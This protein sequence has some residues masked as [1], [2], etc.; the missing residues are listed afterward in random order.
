M[1]TASYVTDELLRWK[2]D[3]VARA[4]MIR[5]LAKLCLGWPYVFGAAGGMCTVGNRKSYAG[6]RPDHAAAIRGACPVLSDKQ[7]ACDGCKWV[8]T[9]IFDC[10]GF[11]RWLL[12]QVGVPLFG[13]TVSAQWEDSKNWV[14]KGTSMD[15]LPHGLVCCVFRPSHTGMYT[16]DGMVRHCSGTVKEEALPGKPNWQKWAIP[17]GLY[18]NAELE[19]AGVKFDPA[20]NIPTLRKGNNCDEVVELQALLNAKYGYDLEID[21]AFGA[22]TEAAVKDFQRK[23]GLTADGIVGPKTWAALGVDCRQ[24]ENPPV[25]NGNNDITPPEPSEPPATISIPLADW[26]EIK[27]AIM[28]AYHIIKTYEG[29]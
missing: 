14:A 3:G 29:G 11:T 24:V 19:A 21:G 2:V 25:D 26:Q 18:T 16:G 12:S 10:R 4:V 13:G 22:K 7:P 1:Y 20:K 28:A 9:R 6:S 5:S 17:A 15:T 23:H 8:D 27:A